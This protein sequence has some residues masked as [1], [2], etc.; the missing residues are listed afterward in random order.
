MSGFP[1]RFERLGTVM[2]PDPDDDNEAEGVLNPAGALDADGGIVL[3]PRLVAPGNVSRIGRA[4]VEFTG[5]VPTGVRREGIVL[6]PERSWEHGDDHGGVEDARITRVE[7]LDRWLMTYVAY[8]PLGPRKALAVSQ[9][10]RTWKR[11]GPLLFVYD[12]TADAELNLVF[13]KDV[14]IVPEPV[15]GPGGRLCLAVFHRPMWG[16]AIEKASYTPPGC[17]NRGLAV[18][19]SYVDLERAAADE[20]LLT[21]LTGHREVMRPEQ[22]WEATKIGAGAPPVKVREGWLLTYHGVGPDGAGGHVYRAGAAL[23]DRHDPGH[24][25]RR[26]A[27]PLLSPDLD[28]ERTG[29]VG[30]VVFPTVL[31]PHHTGLLC[32][33]GMADARIGAARLVRSSG[34]TAATGGGDGP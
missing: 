19:L 27:E 30:N 26:S 10:L 15:P 5:S 14:V 17:E 29:T 16:E 32:F 9:D 6:A 1:Y 20:R 18:W 21:V 25:L 31:L 7:A 3:F 11:L 8:G 12:D 22:P 23:L 4:Q 13:N 28:T 2:E 24:V 34:S 33:Y